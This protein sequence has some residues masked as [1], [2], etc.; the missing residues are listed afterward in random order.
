MNSGILLPFSFFLCTLLIS[1]PGNV[2]AS[3][4]TLQS[5]H[6]Y[7]SH[8]WVGKTKVYFQC[9]G[10]ANTLLPD[11][12]KAKVEYTF[13]GEESWQPLTDFSNKKCKRCKLIEKHKLPWPHTGTLDEWEFCPSD[14]TSPDA[15]YTIIKAKEFSATFS[16]PTC[17]H[18][19]AVPQVV[20]AP[21]IEKKG[22]SVAVVVLISSTATVTVIAGFVGGYK[23]WKKRKKRQEQLRF[24][25][26]FEEQDDMDDEL[27][28]GDDL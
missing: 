16:C 6:L 9:K 17:L 19:D 18:R 21:K 15:T 24:M 2:R 20:A 8:E 3:V 27:G 23:F 28:L 7:K 11:V 25:Q 12:K 5:I 26:L 1:F 14:F 22:L 10:E 13:K 4:V